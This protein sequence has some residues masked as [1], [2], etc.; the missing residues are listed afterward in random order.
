M[1]NKDGAKG[2]ADKVGAA[3]IEVIEQPHDIFGH[4]PKAVVALDHLLQLV[5]LAMATQVQQQ[6]VEVFTIGGAA[7]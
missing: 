3:D 6:H 5:G 7:A 1:A 4:F 2:Y